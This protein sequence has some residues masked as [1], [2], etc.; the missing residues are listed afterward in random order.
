VNAP[1][2]YALR[3]TGAVALALALLA[4]GAAAAARRSAGGTIPRDH[5]RVALMPFENL[6]GR[7]DQSEVFTKVFFAQLVA[8][9]AFDV[10][11]PVQVDAAMDSLRIRATGSMTISQLRAM[12]DTL[13]APYMMLGSVLESGIVKDPDGDIPSVGAS[14]RLVEASTGRVAWAG[15]QFMTGGD[16]ETVFGWGRVRS[17][18]TL[19]MRLAREML[20]DF[21][22]HGK[23]ARDS[24]TETKR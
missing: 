16:H 18:E 9:G 6:S 21:T 10:V 3:A 22:E 17:A 13:H 11:D 2:R 5:P 1:A 14:V 7:E 12:A 8:T 23:R 20:D 4:G 15:V 24:H 19:V